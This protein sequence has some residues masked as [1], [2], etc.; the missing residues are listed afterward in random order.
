MYLI[1]IVLLS[2]FQVLRVFVQ[3]INTLPL[4]PVACSKKVLMEVIDSFTN[5]CLCIY[6]H[7]FAVCTANSFITRLYKF[8]SDF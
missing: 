3:C 5:V 4:L 8:D 2:G 6:G 1:C 7:V